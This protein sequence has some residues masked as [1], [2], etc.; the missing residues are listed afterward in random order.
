MKKALLSI[1]GLLFFI[2]ATAQ[3]E[4]S[5]AN[6]NAVTKSDWQNRKK[7]KVFRL[8]KLN[9][10]QMLAKLQAAP[11]EKAANARQNVATIYL[12]DAEGNFIEFRVVNAPVAA[13]GL[14]KKYPDLQSFSGVSTDG[15]LKT[16]R[17]SFTRL[18]LNA[19]I[20][21]PGKASLFIRR[22]DDQN[23]IYIGFESVS[24][25][26]EGFEC[27]SS[28]DGVSIATISNKGDLA[29]LVPLN[30][31]TGEIR[32][33]RFALAASG[34]FSVTYGG[35]VS[36]S[37]A[38]RRAN[39]LAFQVGHLTLTNSFL[40]RDFGIRLQLIDNNED[41]IFLDPATDG[42]G[43]ESETTTLIDMAKTVINGVLSTSDYDL[44][45][46]MHFNSGSNAGRASIGRF[47]DDDNKARAVT[48]RAGWNNLDGYAS[49]MFTHEIGHQA[50]A[51]HTFTHQDDNDNAQM[52]PG[53]GNTFMSYG[54][55][56]IAAADQ[57]IELRSPYF[58]AISIQQATAHIAG[59]SCGTTIDANN[60][61]PS[62]NAGA[63]RTIPKSTA[64]VLTGVASDPESDPL[65]FT[66]EQ[67]DK[68]TS[69]FG[70]TIPNSTYTTGPMFRS[71][72]PSTSPIRLM[73]AE[74]VS[75]KWETLPSVARTM[76]F[77][78]TV[79][80]G[81]QTN[82]DNIVITVADVGPFALTA[83][84]G[85]ETICPGNYNITWNAEGTQALSANVKISLSTDGGVNWSV[86]TASTPN[87]GSY[88]HDFACT[89]SNNARI[90][91]E[92]VENIFYDLSNAVFTIGDNTKPTFN[93]PA[94]VTLYK[95]EDCNYSALPADTGV[96][97]DVQDNCD[98]NPD[99]WHTDL[100]KNGSC[101]G[102]TILE[103]TWYV[104]DACGND[105]SQVQIITVRDTTAPTFTV[106]DDIVI[107]KDESCDYDADP[108]ITGNPT[109]V[110]D[111][112]DPNPDPTY[113]DV[114]EE[115]SCMGE[116]IITRTWK[117]TDDCGNYTQA[118][119]IITA[120]DTTAP[121]FENV[122]ATPNSLWPPNHKMREVKIN[123]DVFDNCSDAAHITTSLS[124]VS[125]EPVNGTGDGDTEPVDYEVIDNHTVMLRAE[126]AGTGDGRVYTIT[127]TA[128]DDCG[129]ISST[130]T[131]VYVAHNITSPQAGSS[132]KV[133]STV[134][135]AGVFQ[136]KPGNR[137][138][139]TWL[140]DDAVSVKGQVAAE[141]NG[142]KNGLVTGSY[143]FMEP[144]VYKV[145][146][147]VKDQLGNESYVSTSGDQEATIVIY[148]PAGG[149][150]FGG[151]W[152]AS[153]AGALKADPQ[154]T[155]KASFGFEVHYFKKST[156]PKGET[157]FELKV[158]NFEFTALN[159][160]YM[161]IS[162]NRAQMKGYGRITNGQSGIAFIL[163]V[164]DNG[165]EDY[166]RVRIY[167]KNTGEV[168]YDNEPGASEAAAPTT[169]T[170]LS[171]VVQIIQGKDKRGT[172]ALEYVREESLST[173]LEV[174][175]APNPSANLFNLHIK[176]K[177]NAEPV[178]LN[179]YNAAGI[180]VERMNT[181]GNS[182]IAVGANWRPGLYVVDV[183]QGENRMLIKLI[184][185]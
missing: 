31:N 83:P 41:I 32:T 140:I 34:Q 78:F 120:M 167:N 175:S 139:A 46:L 64:F 129:N 23:Q 125:N 138:T 96:P 170:G 60:T 169:R 43:S 73:P 158:G 130:T 176:A 99:V 44:G 85:G 67:M 37:D 24:A 22:V 110:D 36:L 177:N 75:T 163:T 7:P 113:T 145:R 87:D 174:T 72:P 11:N 126:R 38:E 55:N 93:V 56:G 149:N 33:F 65:L 181:R 143:K 16:T 109:N 102:E 66:W 124:I 154:A 12:P 183:Q 128:E 84:N 81:S 156:F 49:M 178:R 58:H 121:Y 98:A 47:C 144:G 42:I 70:R 74:G 115:G 97:T 173:E 119:Q 90:K 19:I 155:G 151:G 136:D 89:Y 59:V 88:T 94:D 95:D 71:L 179:V 48:M 30:A 77:R 54:G 51:N 111:N 29:G 180:A 52:E 8:Y 68:L 62:A 135:L 103:R 157:R 105:S 147:N 14:V 118:V 132:F 2:L 39:V 69:D 13:P 91:I 21:E 152:F 26:L 28:G 131:E 100:E 27:E 1:A 166:V 3:P 185:L 172:S 53:S 40:E 148:D 142:R 79:R 20:H 61:A 108:S 86:I 5:R 159:Y 161:A 165:N 114:V 117:V 50:G 123:Y 134:S 146:M 82:S 171:S 122:S 162:G 18:G 57:V 17:F 133:G 76:N 127:I 160:D 104:K 184:K 107:Y 9:E 6:E 15:S 182:T 153:P 164:I 92:A 25:D 35:N 4:W 112:C 45:H 10:T 116:E 101:T 63:D 141:P 137:H 106:P 150:A 168:Y 80:D